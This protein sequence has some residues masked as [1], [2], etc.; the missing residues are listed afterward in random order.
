MQHTPGIRMCS[1]LVWFTRDER[2]PPPLL[3]T[4]LPHTLY[5]PLSSPARDPFRQLA[6]PTAVARCQ[7]FFGTDEEWSPEGKNEQSRPCLGELV[8]KVVERTHAVLS[9]VNKTHGNPPPRPHPTP[10][11]PCLSVCLSAPPPPLPR[12]WFF[13]TDRPSR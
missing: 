1:V 10:P 13:F 5:K 2:P 7:D 8:N 4:S 9:I 6:S 12:R 3:A 11:H